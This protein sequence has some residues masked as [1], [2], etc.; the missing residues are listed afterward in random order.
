[1]KSMMRK[2]PMALA[3]LLVLAGTAWAKVPAAEADKL[4][5]ELNCNGGIKAGNK[6]GTIPEFTGKYVGKLPGVDQPKHSGAHPVDIYANEKPLFVIT[7]ENMDKYADKLSDGQKAMLKKYP[8]TY[9]MPVYPGHRDF[10]YPED[11]CAVVKKNALEAEL[12]DDGLAVKAGMGGIPFPIPQNGNEALWNNLIPARAF[13]ESITRD[14]ANVLSDGSIAWGRQENRNLDETSTPANRGKPVE[15][16]MAYSMTRAL[17]PE[18][19]KGGVTNSTEPLNFKKD[20]RLAWS[21]DAG[22]RRVRQVPEYGFD[23]P[24]AGSGGKMT[25]DSDRLFNGSPERYNWKLLGRKEM[26]IP[27]NAY[28]IHE[29]TVKYKD[30][31]TPNHANPDFMRYELRRVWAVEG[32]LKDNY[33]HLYGKR[34]LFLDEDTGQAVASDMY[35]SRGQLWQH[36]LINYYYTP[37][38]NAWHAGTSFYYDLNSGS[39]IGY[40][41]FQERPTGP[42]LNKG[43]LDPSMFT[44][45][46]AR[47]MGT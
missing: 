15:G 43:D 11:V 31:L 44:P 25:I 41:L 33:R 46:A 38:I 47:N 34:V 13:T 42:V 1:M 30:L 9:K 45:Q 28:K 24:L 6:D 36:A 10:A 32:N 8:T 27:A 2:T 3:A 14:V 21:Y 23:Q 4:G 40:N 18:R 26:F 16:R 29:K 39:Y 5:K 7:A 19:E 17:L 37:D 20:K 35:D 22:T 12:I